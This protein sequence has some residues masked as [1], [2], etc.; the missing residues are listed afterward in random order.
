LS[1]DAVPG[2]EIVD[3]VDSTVELLA[4]C[5]TF[6]PDVAVLDLAMDGGFDAIRGLHTEELAGSIVVLTDLTNGTA[7][8]GAL[9]LGV[10]AYLIKSSALQVVGERILQVIAGE[11]VISAEVE[12]VAVVELGRFAQRAREGSELRATLTPREREI[13]VLIGSG[14]TMRQMATRLGI[15]PRT[16]ETHVAKLYRKLEVRTR[17]QAVSRAVALGLIDLDGP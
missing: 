3:E 10:G 15:S 12:Q 16:V 1:C 17:V 6:H 7:V 2:L 14:L 8:L 13:L 5:R 11:R 4:S 9:R